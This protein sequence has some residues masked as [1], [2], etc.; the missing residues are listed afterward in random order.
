MRVPLPGRDYFP[1]RVLLRTAP[2]P[3]REMPWPERRA[4]GLG[5]VPALP[6]SPAFMP[7]SPPAPMAS[8]QPAA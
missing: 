8:L 1:A 6:L 2:S 5:G 3:R 7:A 4:D